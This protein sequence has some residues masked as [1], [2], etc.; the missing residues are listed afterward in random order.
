MVSRILKALKANA[1]N[2]ALREILELNRVVMEQR[3]GAPWVEVEGGDTLLVRVQ[4]ETSELQDQRYLEEGWDYDYF[5]GSF[6]RLAGE[7]LGVPWK[8]E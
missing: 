2:D 3:G 8:L 7:G 1:A 4:S 6:I 5:L